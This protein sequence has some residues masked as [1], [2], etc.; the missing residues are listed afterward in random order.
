[1]L[2]RLLKSIIN[3]SNYHNHFRDSVFLMK[4]NIIIKSLCF[5]YE[6]KVNVLND[7]SFQVKEGESVGIIAFAIPS[8]P[9]N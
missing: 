2:A 4:K 7:I 5:S 8:G 6:D 3:N 1:M 9:E